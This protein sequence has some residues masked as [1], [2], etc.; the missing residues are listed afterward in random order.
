MDSDNYVRKDTIKYRALQ[1]YPAIEYKP[2]VYGYT[3]R[4]ARGLALLVA[5]D[6]KKHTENINITDLRLSAP[7]CQFNFG[8][9]K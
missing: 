4:K 3:E 6:D 8:S 7:S 5:S 2:S 1:K 9:R